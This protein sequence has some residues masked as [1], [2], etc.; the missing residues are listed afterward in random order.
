VDSSGVRTHSVL[1]VN[2]L[3][4]SLGGPFGLGVEHRL[5]AQHEAGDSRNGWLQELTWD[6]AKHV[7]LGA[8]YNFAEFSDNEFSRN[9]SSVKGWFLRLQGR[10]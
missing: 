7:R 1:V 5:L 4:A 9:D 10:Y 8:G 2:R 3:N 6:P